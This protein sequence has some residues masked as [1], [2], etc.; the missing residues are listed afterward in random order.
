MLGEE[1]TM[2]GIIMTS[3]YSITV[4][5]P[6]GLRAG[7]LELS[8]A[9]E[10]VTGTLSLLGFTQP[11]RGEVTD[12][13]QLRLTHQLRTAVSQMDCQSLLTL[14]QDGISGM[15][16]TPQGGMP[17]HGILSSGEA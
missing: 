8:R 2:G 5:S 16:Y 11:V 13:G 9:Q 15:M 14:S 7:V 6:M 1:T 10:E 3:R 17:L 4:E 12:P